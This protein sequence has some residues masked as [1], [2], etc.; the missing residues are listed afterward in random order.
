MSLSRLAFT[1]VLAA[2]IVSLTSAAALA[3]PTPK[4]RA[5]ARTLTTAAKKA[6]KDQRWGD[7]VDALKQA[8]QLAPSAATELDLAQAQIKAGKLL[9]AKKTLAAVEGSTGSAHA[10]KKARESAKKLLAELEVKIPIVKVTVKG[11]TGKA[12]VTV[13]GVEVDASGA[14]PVDPGVH[15]VGASAPGFK[16]MEKEMKLAE[17]ARQSVELALEPDAP[18]PPKEERTGSRVPGIIVTGVG[19]A[20]LAIGGV[21]GGLAFSATSA[22]KSQCSGNLCPPSAESDI[23]RSKLF[24][25]VSTGM[26]VAGGAVAVAGVVLTILAPGGKKKDE[27]PKSGR[28]VPWVG[29]DQV[30]IAGT[31]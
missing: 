20:A 10:A 15:N 26:L 22:A 31:F 30:G 11:P 6:M 27:A 19:G 3:G 14:I 13:D 18:P 7:A 23:S 28:V 5:E 21:F 12:N 1:P 4:Q 29:A 17:G 16:A 24:G 9:D 8:D 25:N 2:A